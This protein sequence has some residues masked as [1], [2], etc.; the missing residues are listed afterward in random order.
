MKH[1]SCYLVK[2]SD[3]YVAIDA[4]WAGCMNEYLKELHLQG[5]RP[6][7]IKYLF[8]THF[9]PDHAGLA[10]N[11]KH[12]G[13]QLILFAHQ[14]PYVSVMER[15][16]GK[17]SSYL[18]LN[19][20]SSLTLNIEESD[21]FFDEHHIPVRAVR[22]TGHSEDSISLVFSDGTAFIGDLC[23]PELLMEDDLESRSSWD[24]L[25][26]MGVTMVYPAHRAAF[27]LDG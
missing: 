21:A 15:M 25:R 20:Q 17:N 24:R 18:P 19:L 11:I 16:I 14:I 9:H 5:I 23:L 2:V 27:R 12:Y 3:Y 7:Q 13:A 6:E 1:V 22:T 8:L 26:D 10:E 4:G